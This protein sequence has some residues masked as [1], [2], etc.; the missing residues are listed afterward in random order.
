M[1]IFDDQ[2]RFLR[3]FKEQTIFEVMQETFSQFDFVVKDYVVNKQLFQEGINGK[4]I[5]LPKYAKST[6]SIKIRKRQPTDRTTLHDTERFVGSI[7]IDTMFDRFEITSNVTYDKY[8]IER[9]G[10]ELL[11]PTNENIRDFL[12]NFYLPKLKQRVQQDLKK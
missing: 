11:E 9:Y 12:M 10:L 5:K 3:E 7:T 4:G 6:I 8:I 1:G 2:I